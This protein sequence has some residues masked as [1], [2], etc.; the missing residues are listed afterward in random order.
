MKKKLIVAATA[1]ALALAATSAFA[2]ENE[3]HG[4][5]KFMGYETN[6]WNGTGPGGLFDDSHSGWFAEQRA[7]LQ[8]I[9]KANDNLKLVTQF[10]LDARFGGKT[11][12][13][14]GAS[15]D[16]GNLDADQLTLETKNIYLDFNCPI[17]GTNVKAG[18]QPWADSYQSLYLLADMSGLYATKKFDAFTGSLGWFRIDDNTTSS[19]DGP[20]ELSADLIVV[21]GKFTI[22]KDMKVGA[23]YY[24]VQNDANKT[25]ATNSQITKYDLLHTFGLN[26]D[27]TFGPAN[28]KPFAL[29]QMGEINDNDD[30]NGYLL[31]ATAKIK[32]GTTGAVNLAGFYISGDDE[33]TYTS[34]KDVDS[35]T[36]ISAN[37][38]YF[39][40]ANMWLLIRNGQ[41]VNSSF[42]LNN[43]LTYGGR[44][45][46]GL[47]AGYEG[48]VDK[49]FYNANIGYMATAEERNN[50]DGSIGTEINCQVGYKLFDNLSV[51]VAAAYA[52]LGDGMTN[53]LA[54][55]RVGGAADADDPWM[56]NTQLSY[57]F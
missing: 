6:F 3:F 7:R 48:K 51:S 18:I 23:T 56:L 26:A 57:A 44:G 4:M 36:T 5:Y 2:L 35:F 32:V 41:A 55:E 13:Y 29:Y 47:F 34:G 15:N 21:D 43:D 24:L 12:A 22:N 33:N 31:G 46:Y 50:E 28:V 8:Y 30:I 14:L 54:A 1:G 53:D 20:G 40:A 37:A 16:G 11:G 9:A 10:E 25:D 45:S 52:V 39:N 17:T 42:G 27:L 49:L 38:T 19:I